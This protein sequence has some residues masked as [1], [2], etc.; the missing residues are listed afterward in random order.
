M[1]GG[2]GLGNKGSCAF[3]G[4]GSH[5][6]SGDFHTETSKNSP[7]G[8]GQECDMPIWSGGKEG[9][10]VPRKSFLRAGSFE[11]WFLR[12]PDW[13]QVASCSAASFFVR[14]KELTAPP[15]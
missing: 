7:A 14:R 9:L 11:Q 4:S 8:T 13:A 12:Q 10:S 5:T 15:E 2:K 6:S 3:R 1:T